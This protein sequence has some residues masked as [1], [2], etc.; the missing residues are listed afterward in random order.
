MLKILNGFSWLEEENTKEVEECID[1]GLLKYTDGEDRPQFIALESN[2]QAIKEILGEDYNKFDEKDFIGWLKYDFGGC[3]QGLEIENSY[4]NR[5]NVSKDKVIDMIVDEEDDYF[6]NNDKL[7]IYNA[8]CP[9]DKLYYLLNKIG[10]QQAIDQIH[11]LLN[12][13][14][15]Q[16]FK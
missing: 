10:R 9:N 1:K 16:V 7:L 15:T 3:Y 5:I 11:D 6:N 4:N 14:T 13:V 2:I 12:S 8:E